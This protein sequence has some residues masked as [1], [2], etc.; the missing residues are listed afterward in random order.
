MN[1]IVF[2]LFNFGCFYFNIGDEFGRGCILIFDGEVVLFLV[3][4]LF[5]VFVES[6]FDVLIIVV[7]LEF[8]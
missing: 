4:F 8:L 1:C 5:V 2:Y 6:I 3:K 7:I